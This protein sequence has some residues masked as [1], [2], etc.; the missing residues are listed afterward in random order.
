MANGTL[1]VSNI[2][3]SSGSGTITLGQSG[4]TV[5]FS[6]ATTTLNSAMK[7]TPAFSAKKAEENQSIANNTAV[8]CQFDTIVFDTDSCYDTSNYRFTPN[9]SG[10]YCLITNVRCRQTT[11][12]NDLNVAFYKNGS[13]F[14]KFQNN[15]SHHNESMLVT[16]VVEANGTDYFEV[17]MSQTSGNTDTAN[18][19]EFSGYKIIGA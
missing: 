13:G 19:F 1:K 7:M 18:M 15:S 14:N 9:V 6:N 11:D 8:K 2:Q 10:K 3:T 12:F 16:A 5:D 17:F 4:E